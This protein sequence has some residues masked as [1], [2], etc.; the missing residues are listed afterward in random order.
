MTY[1]K[2]GVVLKEGGDSIGTLLPDMFVFKVIL[3]YHGYMKIYFMSFLGYNNFYSHIRLG[4]FNISLYVE[5]SRH[6]L[7]SK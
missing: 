6:S 2:Y 5:F 1:R 3:E 7:M 4:L